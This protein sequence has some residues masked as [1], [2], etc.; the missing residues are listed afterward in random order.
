MAVF[1]ETK[2][3][4]CWLVYIVTSKWLPVNLRLKLSNYN[5]ECN[6]WGKSKKDFWNIYSFIL[7]D[8]KK[9]PFNVIDFLCISDSLRFWKIPR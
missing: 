4:G 5:P 1:H 3:Q 2:R 9:Y 8:C 6:H 7:E